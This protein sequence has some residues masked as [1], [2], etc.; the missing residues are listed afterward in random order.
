MKK[1][2][3]INNIIILL[4]VFFVTL[5]ASISIQSII[6]AWRPPH[7]QYKT[8]DYNIKE[9]VFTNS[10]QYTKEGSLFLNSI[11]SENGLIVVSGD[12]GVG[13][14]SPAAKMEVVGGVKVGNDTSVCNANKEGTIRYDSVNKVFEVCDGLNWRDAGSYGCACPAD[15]YTSAN[16]CDGGNVVRDYTT[17]ACVSGICTPT[18]SKITQTF[19]TYGCSGGVCSACTPSCT[20]KECGDNGCGGSCGNC[21]SNSSCSSGT[22][23]CNASYADCNG[24]NACECNTSTNHCSG[25]SCVVNTCT[26]F[27]YTAWSSCNPCTNTQTRTV[28]TSSPAGCTGGSP[29]TT[30]TVA[31]ACPSTSINYYGVNYPLASICGKC[32]FA[33]NLRNTNVDIGTIVSYCNP[34]TG[35]GS[36]WGRLYSWTVATNNTLASG[37]GA[38]IRGICPAGWHIPSGYST[39][40]ANDDIPM[41]VA[42]GSAC[43]RSN[44]STY[45]NSPGNNS[46]GFNMPAAGL[47]APTQGYMGVGIYAEMW[48]SGPGYSSAEAS[49]L[50]LN[51]ST[52]ELYNNNHRHEG[53]SVRC[54]LD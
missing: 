54:V 43:L 39:S 26:S 41:L 23:V 18:V 29:V 20:G 5:G 53:M 36:P 25:T 8:S 31:N 47:Y 4:F 49:Q 33:E 48:A 27:T 7:T 42:G 46:S 45:W 51:S 11:N 2:K 32:W 12:V 15:G 9:P 35:C 34:T 6:A 3:I 38:K 1:I 16:Y 13:T 30:Q 19:C 50:Y 14:N 44:S 17:Y 21:G 10:S 40:C 52:A 37:C 22:C 24:D 28:L